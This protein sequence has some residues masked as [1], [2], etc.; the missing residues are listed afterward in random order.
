[1]ARRAY[2]AFLLFVGVAALCGSLHAQSP[3]NITIRLLDARTG[4]PVLPENFMVR[5]DHQLT[6]HVDWVT[7]NE[8]GTGE[9]KIPDNVSVFSL[10]ATYDNSMS[11]YINC[12]AAKPGDTPGERWYTVADILTAGFVA[13]NGC[14]KPKIADKL[15]VTAKPGEFVLFVRRHNW[16]EQAMD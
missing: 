13:P 4:R 1:M 5:I 9:F 8:D 3:R 7:H 14:V 11:I 10:H 15:K 6:P 16:M 12:D 2:R